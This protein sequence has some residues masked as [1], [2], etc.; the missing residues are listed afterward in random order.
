M[1]SDIFAILNSECVAE[2]S[3]FPNI[4][5]EEC[6]RT[7]L[8]IRE[9]VFNNL[10]YFLLVGQYVDYDGSNE[11]IKSIIQILDRLPTEYY[12][13]ASLEVKEFLYN[14]FF[15]KN[16]QS[17]IRDVVISLKKMC[18]RINEKLTFSH[19]RF[20]VFIDKP[21]TRSKKEIG[22]DHQLLLDVSHIYLNMELVF[23]D[24]ALTPDDIHLRR[25]IEMELLFGG[26]L[27]IK[28]Y[29][30]LLRSKSRFLKN[31]IL[32]RKR[33]LVIESEQ[34]G[35]S[36]LFT[37]VGE[38]IKEIES[39]AL[40]E[41]DAYDGWIKY[42]DSHYQLDS[43]WKGTVSSLVQPLMSKRFDECTAHQLHTL[44]K[45]YK[46]VGFQSPLNIELRQIRKIFQ[47]RYYMQTGDGNMFDAHAYALCLNYAINN[48]FSLLCLQPGKSINEVDLLYDEI[49]SIQHM[50]KI[51]NFFP[52]Y[53]YLMT[54]TE[55][56]RTSYSKR[57][58]IEAI[59]ECSMLIERGEKLYLD[60]AKSID[61][62]KRNFNFVFQLP[63]SDCVLN[64]SLFDTKLFIYSSFLLPLD[65][66]KYLESFEEFKSIVSEYKSSIEIIHNIK[67]EI[68]ASKAVR[69]DLGALSTRVKDSETRTME[70][71]AVF[72]A[73]IAFIFGSIQSYNFISSP[74]E[75]AVF[76]L[77]LSS[78]LVFFILVILLA[79]R[80]LQK[81]KE[82][83]Y[84]VITVVLLVVLIW[85]ILLMTAS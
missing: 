31:K 6:K 79:T 62:S 25:L 19:R 26:E 57:K 51:Y 64:S 4:I 78:S 70:V 30:T 68:D 11:R 42:I 56:L 20:I 73:L 35:Q 9:D 36:K 16:F 60:Y 72:T 53:K 39:N 21:P 85:W 33:Q 77:A 12:T 84:Y 38:E 10:N 18:L 17:P 58:A 37:F 27:N 63:F 55:L 29:S 23:I 81:F 50:T 24:H 1:Q 47:E 54:I 46:D 28:P 83:I 7:L 40:M 82:H 41:G 32:L 80:G 59:E 44:V 71:L 13:G 52:Q 15:N 2:D 76:T 5:K 61:W 74:A 34:Y 66:N 69:E 75:A 65:K 22:L 67:S 14:D 49:M 48:E 3:L 43:D 8:S 45:Y